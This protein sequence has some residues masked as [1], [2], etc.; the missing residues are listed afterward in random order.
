MA[1]DLLPDY[2]K[3]QLLLY[4]E[5][6][7]AGDLI[8]YGARY[9]EAGRIPDALEFYQKAD[10]TAGLE[11]IRNTA[12]QTGDVMLFMQASKALGR[13]PSPEEW[14]AVGQAAWKAKKYSFA[15]LAF[16]KGGHDQ[17]LQE[18]EEIVKKEEIV[19][20]R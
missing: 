17:L 20:N 15:L 6:K 10:Y 1:T 2:R 3:K 4:T 5:Q 7:T 14:L 9:L 19:A 18:T 13:T 16:E 8:A 12:Q 11:A